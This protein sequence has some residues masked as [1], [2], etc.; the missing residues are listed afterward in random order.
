MIILITPGSIGEISRLGVLI[1]V[2]MNEAFR[3][4]KISKGKGWKSKEQENKTWR[5][6]LISYKY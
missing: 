1:L 4:D 2:V 5:K 3:V 6:Y